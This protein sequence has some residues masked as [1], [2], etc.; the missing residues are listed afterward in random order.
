MDNR[1]LTLEKPD[2][3][4]IIIKKS[5]FITS[6][7]PVV[8]EEEAVK[9]LNQIKKEHNQANH[10][11]FAYVI[12]EQIQRYS[13]DGEPGGTAGKPVLEVIN[14]KGLEK[15]A[16]VVTRYF[17]GIMLGAGGLVRAYAEAAVKGI[18][19]AGIIE[20]FLHQ[21]LYITMDYHW[22]GLVKREV[23]NAGGKQVEIAYHQQVEMKVC[24]RPE[25]LE[26]L[27]KRLV[28]MTAAQVIIKKGHFSYI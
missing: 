21:E 16:V 4:C 7:S 22:Q 8:D 1:L 9:F 6:V 5:R 26:L 2:R 11:V 3:T 23:E 15:T 18:E 20:K 28:D 14:N 27:D 17:G 19:S 25:T 12:N 13:D 10:N 24:L